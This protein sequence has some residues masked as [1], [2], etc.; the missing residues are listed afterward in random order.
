[1]CFKV[2]F[3][4]CWFEMRLLKKCRYSNIHG[5]S[6]ELRADLC[7]WLGRS[8]HAKYVF[9][10][11]GIRVRTNSYTRASSN[12][13]RSVCG[14][15]SWVARNV[16]LWAEQ[17]KLPGPAKQ[18]VPLSWSTSRRKAPLRLERRT[19][20]PALRKHRSRQAGPRQRILSLFV[21][22]PVLYY[23]LSRF[24]GIFSANDRRLISSL[25]DFSIFWWRNQF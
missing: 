21:Q 23:S 14:S 10:V 4:V 3:F 1:M 7:S 13:W 11:G 12:F 22:R 15:I 2:D 17:V 19:K 8:N 5:G 6:K 25:I 24:D 9:L 20:S 16:P 18:V